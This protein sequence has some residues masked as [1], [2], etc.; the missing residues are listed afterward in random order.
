MTRD[1][2]V[3]LNRQRGSGTRLLLDYKLNE[4]GIEPDSI[5]G[6]DREEY[7]HLAVAAAVAGGRADVGL[8]ILSAANAMGLDFVPL[9]SEQ[10]DLVIPSEHYESERVQFVLSLI[11]GDSFRAEVNALGGYETA[12]MGHVVAELD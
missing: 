2:I 9:L 8:G 4:L 7:T 12:T 3:F 1:G 6:Y 11:R 5:Q 10:Y